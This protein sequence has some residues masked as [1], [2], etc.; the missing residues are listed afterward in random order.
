MTDSPLPSLPNQLPRVALTQIKPGINPRTEFNQGLLIE[1]AQSLKDDGGSIQPLVVYY[2]ECDGM[3]GLI[4]GERRW[5]ASSIAGLETVEIVVRPK[6]SSAAVARKLALKENMQRE[7]LTPLEIA[8]AVHEMLVEQNELGMPIYNKARLAEEIGKDASFITRCE[9][10]LKCSQRVQLR[11]HQRKTPLEI[12]AMI[13]AQPQDMHEWLETEIVYRDKPMT[14]TEA[15]DFISEEVRRDLNNGQFSQDDDGLV[16]GKPACHACEFWGGNRLD[17]VGKAKTRTCLNPA[18][19]E[20]KQRAYIQQNVSHAN[21]GDGVPMIGQDLAD[22]IFS[23]DGVTVKGDSGYVAADEMPDKILLVDPKAKTEKW[24]PLLEDSGLQ[25]KKIVDGKGR[26]RTLYDAKLAVQAVTEPESAVRALFKSSG[27]IKSVASKALDEA[28]AAKDKAKTMGI[29]VAGQNWMTKIRECAEP[30]A[31]YDKIA[32]LLYERLTEA[33]DRDWMAKALGVKDVMGEANSSASNL[34]DVLGLALVARTLRLQGPGSVPGIAADLA[35]LIGFDAKK[36]ARDIAALVA[37]AENL[38][39]AEA[40]EYTEQITPAVPAEALPIYGAALAARAARSAGYQVLP[41]DAQ[42]W[43]S[44]LLGDAV[45]QSLPNAHGVMVRTMKPEPMHWKGAKKSEWLNVE[46][47]YHYEQRTWHWAAHIH[48][49]SM[50]SGSPARA[51]EGCYTRTDAVLE[52]LNEIKQSTRRHAY[53]SRAVA[54]IEDMITVMEEAFGGERPEAP[55]LEEG[56]VADGTAQQAPD[57][58]KQR[59]GKSERNEEAEKKALAAYLN[60]GSIAKAAEACGMQ[61]ESVK[62]WH[63]RRSWKALREAHLAKQE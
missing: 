46:L 59:G 23:F 21:E 42:L 13:G 37:K 32:R 35:T 33:A 36:E 29:L 16:P 30:S 22:K 18:C 8:R 60:T 20:L 45:P 28:Q 53:E 4:A 26:V 58:A 17:V 15:R 12:A 61:V 43:I 47:A 52:A 40:R 34:W 62:N 38:K 54:L 14:L 10:V 3:Y 19:F 25:C 11:V 39:P 56:E 63:K 44:V 57:P 51:S 50:G 41:M 48:E 9:A 7:D 24:G 1:L 6:P 55:G 31:K 27:A 49:G 2:D 5:R